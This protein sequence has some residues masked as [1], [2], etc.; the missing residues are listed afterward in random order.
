MLA[1]ID[2]VRIFWGDTTPELLFEIF[3]RTTVLFIFTLSMLRLVGHRSLSQLSF[4]EFVLIIALGSAVGDPMFYADIP[5]IHGMLVIALIMVYQFITTTATM[6]SSSAARTVDGM[7]VRLVVDGLIDLEGMNKAR[8]TQQEMFG[9][10]RQIGVRELGEIQRAYLETD[11][12]I[13][14]FKYPEDQ[15]RIGL[16]IMPRNIEENLEL[17]AG[18]I[19]PAE[20]FYSCLRCGYTHPMDKGNTLPHCPRCQNE[21]WTLSRMP[22]SILH[23]IQKDN[24]Q[25]PGTP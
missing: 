14:M 15:V 12:Q 8:V 18:E 10:L 7:P 24:H 2:L 1:E 19:I 25:H 4:A 9:E 5:L 3:L 23:D 13:S 11:G 20:A 16:P 21:G 22:S 6:R 17:N